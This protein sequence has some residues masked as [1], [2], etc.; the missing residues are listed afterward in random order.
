MFWLLLILIFIA[1]INIS[2]ILNKLSSLIGGLSILGLLLT[3]LVWLVVASETSEIDENDP[4]VDVKQ[5]ELKTNVVEH[6]IQFYYI[7]EEDNVIFVDKED[8]TPVIYQDSRVLVKTLQTQ[9][10]SFFF[11]KDKFSTKKEYYIKIK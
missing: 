7:D 10:K 11:L 6:D 2:G 1:L 8:V 3:C 9:E 5:Y 4:V